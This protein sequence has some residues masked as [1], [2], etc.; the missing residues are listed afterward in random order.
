MLGTSETFR[1][2]R[3]K[4]YLS[5]NVENHRSG[6]SLIDALRQHVAND[7]TPF[8]QLLR[9]QVAPRIDE[10]T[11]TLGTAVTGAALR[12]LSL[13]DTLERLTPHHDDIARLTPEQ[14]QELLAALPPLTPAPPA[15]G[16]SPDAARVAQL[17][18]QTGGSA[19]TDRANA[20]LD[21]SH[22][23]FDFRSNRWNFANLAPLILTL[24][25]E[26]NTATAVKLIS[27]KGNPS[28]C[29]LYTSPSPR[30][31]RGSRMP[32]SA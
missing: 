19:A 23:R 28:L 8:T 16:L 27:V 12:N 29:L 14:Q 20:L 24:L 4:P 30:D 22:R 32:S 2:I 31:Q 10:R 26:D 21:P 13:A 7:D 5:L 18:R 25:Q 6:R 17:L 1:A 3:L 11:P 15:P 9:D